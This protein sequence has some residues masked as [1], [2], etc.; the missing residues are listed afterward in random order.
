MNNNGSVPVVA[1]VQAG[2]PA[3]GGD[4]VAI[5]VMNRLGDLLERGETKAKEQEKKKHKRTVHF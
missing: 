3:A 2:V 5:Q 4:V 1:A